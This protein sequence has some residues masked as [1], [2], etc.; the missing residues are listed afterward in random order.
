MPADAS[1]NPNVAGRVRFANLDRPDPETDGG[2]VSLTIAPTGDLIYAD[3]DRG[4][5]RRIHYYGG[6]VPPVASFTATPS[7]GPAPLSGVVQREWLERRQWRH[8]H[9]RLGPRRRRAVRRRDRRDDLANVQLGRRRRCRPP[10]DRH[11]WRDRD[12]DADRFRGQLATDGLDHGP[13]LRSTWQVGQ[14][15]SFSGTGTDPQ[16]G[17]LPASAFEWTLDDGALPVRLPLAHHHVVH[18]REVRQ[19]R[20]AGPRVPVAPEAD[21]DRHRLDAA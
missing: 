11:G 20:C 16:D 14:T 7:F 4:E 19:L 21:R 13:R 3:Y 6:N 2:A 15:I 18:G 1:G 5:V 9:L 10:G 12:D 8:A 17:T